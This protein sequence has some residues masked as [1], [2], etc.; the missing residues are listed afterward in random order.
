MP[1]IW[2]TPPT[3]AEQHGGGVWDAPP[4]PAELHAAATTGAGEAL[5]RGGAQGATLGFGDE[6]QGAVQAGLGRVLP[7]SLGGFGPEH[8]TSLAEDYQ[9][10]RDVARKENADAAQAHPEAF[11]A[12]SIAGG[13]LPAILAPGSGIGAGAA[14]G[15]ASGLGASNADTVAGALEDA[16]KGAALGA[17]AAGVGKVL[18]RAPAVAGAAAGVAKDLPLATILKPTSTELSA[19]AGTAATGVAMGHPHAGLAGAA[20][21]LLAGVGK[22]AKDAAQALGVT[23]KITKAAIA[24]PGK[25]GAYGP[26]LSAAFARGGQQELDAHLYSLGQSD[27][28]AQE[29]FRTIAEEKDGN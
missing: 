21:A 26:L 14:L 24:T 11:T 3:E 10:Q 22:R 17:G 16:A 13:A 29:I 20:T 15:G 7:E 27:P 4:T 9:Q 23:S 6:I 25:F 19:A 5:L 2:D 28:K 18:A 12:G 1:G 8:K